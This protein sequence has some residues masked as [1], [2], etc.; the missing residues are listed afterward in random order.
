LVCEITDRIY[1]ICFQHAQGAKA[2]AA[3]FLGIADIVVTHRNNINA[4]ERN[5]TCLGSMGYEIQLSCQL[6]QGAKASVAP[7]IGIDIISSICLGSLRCEKTDKIYH[8]SFQHAKE[9]RQVELL[10]LALILL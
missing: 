7:Y 10:S 3:P 2:S 5:N 9:P 8:I 6:P 1:C 4:R